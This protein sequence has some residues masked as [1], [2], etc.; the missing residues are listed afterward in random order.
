MRKIVL[1]ALSLFALLT[2]AMVNY[3][4]KE[5]KETTKKMVE[6]QTES[7]P[8][9]VVELFTSQGCSSCP[10][11]DE[12]LN[13]MKSRTLSGL[14]DL[15]K[16]DNIFPL[17][18]HV[19]YWN[20]LG[21][22]DSFSQKK[23]DERQ[24]EYGSRFALNGVYT[25]QVVINGKAEMV[26]SHG[27]EIEQMIAE[28]LA[29]FTTFSITLSKETKDKSLI[30]NYKINKSAKDYDFNVALVESGISTKIQRGENEGKTLKHDNVVRYFK[31]IKMT[32]NTEG[33]LELPFLPTEK[34]AVILYLQEPNLGAIVAAAKL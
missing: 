14:G 16:K 22:K 19:T 25:P 8:F 5:T 30:I 23:F 29:E 17:S 20:R 9:V 31:T 32:Q 18:F 28:K 1:I 15:S 6:K 10:P 3:S 27:Q 34:Q 24:Y 33:P 2:M 12:I 7:N 11:A 13:K 4:T 26:G 21:W